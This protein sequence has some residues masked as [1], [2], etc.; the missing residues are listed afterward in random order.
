[1]KRLFYKSILLSLLLAWTSMGSYAQSWDFTSIPTS[2]EENLKS[3]IENWKYDSAKKRYSYN[4]VITDGELMANK[5]MLTMMQG[6]HFTAKTADKIRIDAG[7]EL[8]LNGKDVVLTI[9]GLKPGQQVTIVYA[10]ASKKEARTLSPSNLSDIKG[11]EKANGASKHTGTGS[12]T[13]N[14]SVTFTTTDGGINIYSLKVTGPSSN[15]NKEEPGGTLSADHSVAFSTTQNQVI[16]TTNK[17]ETKYY[18]TQ[19]LSDISIDDDNEKVSVNSPSFSDV[20]THLVTNIVFSKAAEQGKGGE[21]VDKGVTITEAKGWLESAYAK[22]KPVNGAQ[23]YQVYVKGGQYEGY[24]KIDKELIRAY[25]DYIRADIPGLKV[26]TYALKVAAV[27]DGVEYLSSEVTGLQVKNYSREGFAH[28]DFSG[29][30]AY[31]NDGTLK[32]GAVVIYV[33]KDNAKTVSAQL[34]S[35]KFTGLQA[36]LNAYQKGNV[37][38][39]LAVRVLGLVKAGQTDS[40]ESSAEGIQIK[41]RKANS[42]LNI[43]IEG[44]GEDATIHGFGFLVRNA[45]SVEFRNLG[46][47]RA[48]DDGISLDTDNSNIWVHHIDVFYGKAGSGDHAKGD[49]AIDVK[50]NSKF[51]TIDHCHFWDTGKSSM[52]GMKNETGPNYITYHHNWFDHSDSRHARIRTMSVHLWNNFYDGC[53]KYGIGAT[54]GSSVFSERNYFRATKDPILISKQGTDRKGTGT[55]SGEAG[56]MVK[57]CGSLFTEQGTGSNYPPITYAADNKSFDFYQVATRE[58]QVPSSVSSLEGGNT[59]NNFDT[60]A[61]LMYSYTPDATVDVPSQVMGYYGAGRLNHGSLQFKFNNAIEDTN[62]AP[63]PALESL[64]DNY[65]GE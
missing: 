26:G 41:G 61:S 55:F 8:Q 59:Y 43:T 64:L 17:G 20:Y 15:N 50:S 36:I 29:V 14:G 54:M 19:E 56:G 10:S 46:I 42:E 12:V 58:E 65:T 27:K 11:F 48:M 60:N 63:I 25:S 6:L 44:I 49:G 13:A 22:W 28:K 39:P 18:N 16:I 47:M 33:N 5:Q 51:I 35:G 32:S 9:V 62:Y 7:K 24:T 2:D 1:M 52:C 34:S 23:T 40:F 31:N 3:D 21:I 37:T 30:G 57:E 53:A 4:Q 45:K 38:T